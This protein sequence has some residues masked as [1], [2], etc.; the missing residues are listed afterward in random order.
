VP[1][2][3]VDIDRTLASMDRVEALVASTGALVIVQ[4]EHETHSLPPFPAALR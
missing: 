4:H 1:V 2:F 3:N